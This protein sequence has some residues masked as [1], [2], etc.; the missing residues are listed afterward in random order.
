MPVRAWVWGEQFPQLLLKGQLESFCF[1]IITSWL[2]KTTD[3]ELVSQFSF[4]CS[5]EVAR[6]IET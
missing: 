2:V 5:V 6:I 3:V 1:S 4:L